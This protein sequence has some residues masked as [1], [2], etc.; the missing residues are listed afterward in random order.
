MNNTP[1][2][3]AAPPAH[4]TLP[5]APRLG[6]PA[7]PLG[8]PAVD[9]LVAKLFPLLGFRQLLAATA[10]DTRVALS[11]GFGAWLVVGLFAA[12]P[13][14]TESFAALVLSLRGGDGPSGWNGSGVVVVALALVKAAV[15]VIAGGA[16][17][18][19][20]WR[21]LEGNRVTWR[22]ALGAALRRSGSV[23]SAWSMSIVAV[24]VGFVALVVPGLYLATA[25]SL[26]VP[27]VM[28]E[29]RGTFAAFKRS[30]FL[31]E[32][33]FGSVTGILAVYGIFMVCGFCVASAFAD[34]LASA[35]AG[36]GALTA[37]CAR[38]LLPA[39]ASL[40]MIPVR[41]VHSALTT[42]LFLRLRRAK[43]ND[44]LA[45]FETTFS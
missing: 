42:S 24:A 16:E 36:H 7:P 6:P 22:E 17:C 34:T 8:S 20:V 35:A 31:V 45:Q 43:D 4:F 40:M 27:A 5:V 15:A 29:H 12:V 38:Y 44:E 23:V 28:L 9:P 19:I 13:Q 10:A 41:F 33:S 3:F 21:V 11:A 25:L 39:A 26:A 32:G 14:W 30:R 18:V 1:S 2:P 37:N